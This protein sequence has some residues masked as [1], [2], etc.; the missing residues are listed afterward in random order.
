MW[1]DFEGIDGSGK[2][3]VSTRVAEELR[4]RGMDVV[5]A[6][7]G[8]RFASPIAGRVRDL[9]RGME[10][11]FLAPEAELLLN[12]AREAQIL[13]ETVRPALARGA[14][15]ITDRTIYSHLG[16]ARHVRGLGPGAAEAAAALAA[17]GLRPDRVF[18]VDVD[19]D[20]ARWRRRVRKIRERRLSDSGRKGL[21]GN[22]LA[23][24]TQKAFLEMA[25]DGAWTVVDNTWRPLEETVRDVLSVLDG[26]PRP[27]SEGR[28]FEADPERLLD[29]YLSYAASLED[30][31]LGAI[32]AAG[33]DD[34]RADALRRAGPADEAAYA[35]TGM[36]A[37]PAWVLREELR[38]RTPYYVARSLAGLG[39]DPRAWRLRR[40]LEE[41]APDQVVASL[42]G[43]SG[44]EAH[45]LRRR[46]WESHADEAL[47][48]L[49]GLSDDASWELRRRARR[50]RPGSPALVESVTGIDTEPAWEIRTEAS[51]HPLSVLR[52]LK[53]VDD[54]RAWAMREELAQ[55]APKLVLP[56]V[57]G[58]G[59]PRAEA[60]RDRLAELAPE[61]TAASL[62]RVETPEAW[63]RREAL[64]DAAPAGVIKSLR[65]A[66]RAREE[67]L[68][69]EIVRS[70]PG[71]LRVAREAAQFLLRAPWTDT[72]I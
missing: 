6:R 1:I 51:K 45:A 32:L 23:Y 64:R 37:L 4:K 62:A 53:G 3:T 13:S 49:K 38:G 2:T 44:E 67:A 12:L 30:R 18:F 17:Q 21:L 66:D 50:E 68:V 25:R 47:R 60:L 56:T 59:G 7:E 54:P 11:L 24:R 29:S 70:H 69:R 8:G 72:L 20:V 39:A 36:V 31:S 40:E 9:V 16:L 35:L 14:W 34:P 61:E 55:V 33:L 10:C 52:S 71:R 19:P 15:V 22:S 41:A 42:G 27:Q 65:S 5:H 63:R 28:R 48:S 57:E 43:D 58:M 26:R 46:R